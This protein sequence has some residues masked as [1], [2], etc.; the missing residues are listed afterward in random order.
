MIG[1]FLGNIAQGIVF[2]DKTVVMERASFHFK[3]I[4]FPFFLKPF[5]GGLWFGIAPQEHQAKK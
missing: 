4:G 3:R 1:S 2:Q 5:N